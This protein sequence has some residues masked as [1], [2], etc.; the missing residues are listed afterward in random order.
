MEIAIAILA[1]G[2]AALGWLSKGFTVNINYN[3]PEQPQP[4]IQVDPLYD[5]KGQ[6][7][8]SDAEKLMSNLTQRVQDIMLGKEVEDEE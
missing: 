1:V 3:V 2:V 7:I 5:D 8:M 6:P 4:E